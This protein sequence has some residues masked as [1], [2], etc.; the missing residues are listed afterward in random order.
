MKYLLLSLIAIILLISCNQKTELNP[1][2]TGDIA[3]E[4]LKNINTLSDTVLL[5][6][7][8]SFD[9]IKAELGSKLRDK[10]YDYIRKKDKKYRGKTNQEILCILANKYV[11]YICVDK[12]EC[13]YKEN[14]PFHLN[15][16]NIEYVR[17]IYKTHDNKGV[18]DH[19]PNVVGV[20]TFKCDSDYFNIK[21]DFFEMNGKYYARKF[22]SMHKTEVSEY[23][24]E[25]NL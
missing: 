20:L 23:N 10:Y 15:F 14:E 19:L 17:Y 7:Q 18:I 6:Y 1:E 13:I 5:E 12:K 22:G 8:A 21:V 24:Q 3:F 11:K 16:S 4:I 2:D 9:D 25:V